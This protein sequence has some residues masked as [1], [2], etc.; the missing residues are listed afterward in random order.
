M[1]MLN[2]KPTTVLMLFELE[3]ISEPALINLKTQQ[4][5]TPQCYCATLVH[6]SPPLI[7]RLKMY[8]CFSKLFR[9]LPMTLFK[10][11]TLG[12]VLCCRS[13]LKHGNKSY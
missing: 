7:L 13:C 12:N 4:E 2:N 8:P 5:T 6:R 11:L 1:F 10:D 3:Q 9:H